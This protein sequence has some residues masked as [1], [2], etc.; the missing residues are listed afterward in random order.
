MSKNIPQDFFNEDMAQAY[1]ERNSKLSPIKEALHFT[2]RLLLQDL[3]KDSKI[4]CVGAGTGSEII[5][6]AKVFPQWNFV[7]LEPSESMLKVCKKRIT[8]EGL[9]NQCKFVHGYIEDLPKQEKFSAILSLF[10]GDFVE[11]TQRIHFFQNMASRLQKDG[12]LIHAEIS[13]DLNSPQF[14]LML[15][16]WEEVQKLMGATPESL[17]KLPHQLKEVLTVLPPSKTEEQI[18]QAGLDC[19]VQFFQTLMICGWFCKK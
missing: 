4:L 14:P 9:A 16:K 17:T 8:E 1:D 6:F 15:E 5:W 7:A 3:P 18:K 13:Y 2:V 19:P 12:Y 10:V 11:N